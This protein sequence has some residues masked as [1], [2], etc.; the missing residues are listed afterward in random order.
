MPPYF[1]YSRVNISSKALFNDLKFS[2]APGLSWKDLSD[3][4]LF[5]DTISDCDSVLPSYRWNSSP[6]IISKPSWIDCK[7]SSLLSSVIR[8][9]T[10]L[11]DI[12]I[13]ASHLKFSCRVKLVIKLRPSGCGFQFYPPFCIEDSASWGLAIL[14]SG[15]LFSPD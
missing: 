5:P 1:R 10:N 6:N 15:G 4:S 11:F 3:L 8:F 2:T 14:G 9:K 12:K 13:R 7:S